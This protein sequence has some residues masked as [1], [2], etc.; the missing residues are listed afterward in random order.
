MKKILF[1]LGL[2]IGIALF[3]PEQGKSSDATLLSAI[4]D[5][6]VMKEKTAA[7]MRHHFEVLSNELK[8]SSF[9]APRR[10]YQTNSNVSEIRVFKNVEKFLQY[11]RLKGE[12]QLL[13]VSQSTSISQTI[14]LSTLLCRMGQH[15]FVLRKLII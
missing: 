12:N 13:K 14:H 7:D 5:E 1:I 15:I 3:A 9:L 4:Q 8:D 11:M 6:P 2:L 10:V